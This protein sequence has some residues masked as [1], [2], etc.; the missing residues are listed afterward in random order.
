MF[1]VK[2]NYNSGFIVMMA[3]KIMTP[4]KSVKPSPLGAK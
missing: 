4:G 3:M 2:P 1:I